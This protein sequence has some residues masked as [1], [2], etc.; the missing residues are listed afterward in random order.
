MAR[1]NPDSAPV[2]ELEYEPSAFEQALAKHRSKLILVG[3]LALAGLGAYYTLKIYKEHSHHSGGLDFVRAVSVQDFQKVA[4]E[5]SGKPAG[6]SAMLMAAQLLAGENKHDEA[7][8]ELENLLKEY[9]AYPLADLAT[10][11]MADSYLKKG[12]KDQGKTLLQKL[13]DTHAKSP[14]APLALLRL[15]DTLASDKNTEEARKVYDQVQKRYPGSE[16][17][18]SI[19][20][21]HLKNL[22]KPEPVM[23]PWV[24]EKPELPPAA[25]GT[26]GSPTPNTELKTP[27]LSLEPESPGGDKPMLELPKLETPGTTPATPEAPKSATPPPAPATPQTPAPPAQ[28]VKPDVPKNEAPKPAPA[29]PAAPV[30]AKP[31]APAPAKPNP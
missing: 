7:I 24:E 27:S 28:P 14:Y 15:A 23:V 10:L 12:T 29:K 9:P 30:P 16:P 1:T 3:V 22:D 19:A 20:E 11:R 25:A 6:A 21:T 31:A 13:A 8:A 26:P 18:F 2:A 5:H 17:F 4:K